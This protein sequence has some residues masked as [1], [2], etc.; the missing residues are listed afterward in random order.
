VPPGIARDRIRDEQSQAKG[1]ALRGQL[2][3]ALDQKVICF[4]GAYFKTKGLDRLLEAFADSGKQLTEKCQVIIVGNDKRSESYQAKAKALGIEQHC[5]FLGQRSDIPDCLFASDLLV[6]PARVENTGNVLLEAAVA[7]IPVICTDVCGYASYIE[8]YQL[9][10]VVASPYTKE[11]L[12]A[13]MTH[14]LAESDEQPISQQQISQQQ[15]SQQQ[16][17]NFVAQADVFSRLSFIVKQVNQML[18][19]TANKKP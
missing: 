11:K 19:T 17:A 16:S 2:G 8:Q 12:V 3:I 7:G 9:G 14:Y 4:I 5:H 1:R 18:E 10:E 15:I 13:A 6:H